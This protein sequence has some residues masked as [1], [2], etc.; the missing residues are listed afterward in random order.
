M[1][2]NEAGQVIVAQ[3]LSSTDG[4]AFTGTVAVSVLGDGGTQT[5]GGGTVA[6][7]GN[8]VQLSLIHI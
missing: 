6:H 1:K 3:M 7:K 5:A 8:G 4:S 2:K